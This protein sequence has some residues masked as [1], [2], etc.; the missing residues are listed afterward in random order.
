VRLP[1]DTRL[2][3][4]EPLLGVRWNAGGTHTI[5]GRVTEALGRVPRPGDR[6][7]ID[8]ITFE[9]ETVAEHA[10]RSVLASGAERRQAMRDEEDA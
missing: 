1:G 5:G 10:V 2:D 9:V 6:V 7:E 8:G 4:L 3:E